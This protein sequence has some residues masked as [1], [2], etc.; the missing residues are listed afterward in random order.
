ML[1]HEGQSQIFLL[2]FIKCSVRPQVK[3]LYWLSASIS[4]NCRHPKPDFSACP[5]SNM[6]DCQTASWTDAAFCVVL[7]WENPPRS[8]HLFKRHESAA[9]NLWFHL[10]EFR[11]KL[12]QLPTLL[13]LFT[14]NKSSLMKSL[15]AASLSTFRLCYG[16]RK[17][18]GSANID[19][20]LWWKFKTT[21]LFPRGRQL[22]VDPGEPEQG[23]VF[24]RNVG[25][26]DHIK[27][28]W[29]GNYSEGKVAATVQIPHRDKSHH[30]KSRKD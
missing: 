16:Q 5:S 2:L 9:S 23:S 19:G 17:S 3:H 1:Y 13:R 24:L 22:H 21:T 14:V 10:Q 8:Q 4:T 25:H 29:S 6:T 30:L 26:Y 11:G 20:I 18:N 7:F 15:S 28:G 27:I 12:W